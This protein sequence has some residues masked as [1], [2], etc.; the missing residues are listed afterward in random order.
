MPTARGLRLR[1]SFRDLE[2]EHFE[3]RNEGRT[4]PTDLETLI[5]AFKG[6]F[7]LPPTDTNSFFMIAGYHGEPFRGVWHV[8]SELFFHFQAPTESFNT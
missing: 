3:A 5:L 4:E 8:F 2:K 1:R 7:E 6:V